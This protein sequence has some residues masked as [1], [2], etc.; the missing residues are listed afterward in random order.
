MY[1]N[2]LADASG[3]LIIVEPQDRAD[4]LFY[5]KTAD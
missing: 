3:G 2:L 5:R 4:S 1:G